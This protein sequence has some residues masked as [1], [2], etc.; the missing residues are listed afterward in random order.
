MLL[1]VLLTIW[2]LLLGTCDF[3]LLSY[4]KYKGAVHAQQTPAQHLR[5]S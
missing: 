1:V 3:D 5:P 4:Q 2:L